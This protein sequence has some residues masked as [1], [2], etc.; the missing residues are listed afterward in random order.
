MVGRTHLAHQGCR[1]TTII[2]YK[3]SYRQQEYKN[4]KNSDT[5]LTMHKILSILYA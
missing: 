4:M 3:I 1:S 2:L 5:L